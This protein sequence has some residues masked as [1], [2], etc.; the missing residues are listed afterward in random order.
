[1]RQTT[2]C[3]NVAIGWGAGDPITTGCNNVVIGP[4]TTVSI[5]SAS[6]QLAIGFSS[7]GYW[8]QGDSTKAIKPGA[9]IRDCAESCGTANQVLVSTGAN[10]IQ[11][12]DVNSVIAAPLYGSFYDT[13]PTVSLTTPGTGQ[14]VALGGTFVANGIS[15]QNG[16]EIHFSA[17]GT[18]NIQFSLQF[19]DSNAS[20][21]IIEV[22]IR[23]NGNNLTNSSSQ[24]TSQGGGK[25][26]ILTVNIVDTFVDTDYIQLYWGSL[27]NTVTLSTLPSGLT[28][29]T[30]S[31]NAIVTVVP[32]GA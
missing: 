31:P 13:T 24:T 21:D 29:G 12:K 1:M 30:G 3:R 2:G 5:P 19:V 8:L 10:A 9:G 14:P 11:W 23:K 27:S 15:V 32:V 26:V 16:S 25:A 20:S 18:Y 22:W 28:N 7:T 17:S 4:N 6:C